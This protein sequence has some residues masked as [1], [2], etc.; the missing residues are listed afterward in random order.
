[1]EFKNKIMLEKRNGMS[2]GKISKKYNC[3]KSTVQYIVENHNL[4]CKKRGRKEILS[5]LDRRHMMT[6][7]LN[8]GKCSISDIIKNLNLNASKTTV[9][10]SLRSLKYKYIDLRRL[11]K[12]SQQTKN[13][14]LEM[15]KRFIVDNVPWDHVV[16]SDEKYFTLDGIDSYYC[17][18]RFGRGQSRIKKF[19]KRS[20]LMVWAMLLPNGLLSYEIMTGKQDSSKY[21]EIIKNKAIPIMKLNY[22]EKLIFQQDNCPIHV[23]RQSRNFFTQSG[24]SLLEWPPYSP[25]I[26]IIENIWPILSNYIYN[27][28]KI[29]NLKDLR[30][31]IKCAFDTFNETGKQISDNLYRSV[32]PRLVSVICKRGDRINY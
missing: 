25:D 9:W 27:G 32:T 31:S 13:R 21:I 22:S 10:R 7:I 5:K 30:Y 8:Q 16:F 1:M 20:G 23:S 3:A 24:I 12:I 28:N 6:E 17:W 26:N 19:L 18:R 4:K 15:A 29:R 14:R 11:F 2:L